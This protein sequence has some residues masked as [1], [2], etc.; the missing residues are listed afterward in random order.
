MRGFSA[1]AFLAVLLSS[2]ALSEDA[3]TIVYLPAKDGK[4]AQTIKLP[5]GNP[6]P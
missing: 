1:F 2:P 3:G 5:V 4:P 6:Q